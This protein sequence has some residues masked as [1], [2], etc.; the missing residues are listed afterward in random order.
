MRVWTLRRTQQGKVMQDLGHRA[1]E[2]GEEAPG[3]LAPLPLPRIPSPRPQR[4]SFPPNSAVQTQ[5]L[6]QRHEAAPEPARP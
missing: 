1:C 3:S 6:S 5:E 4:H 2:T